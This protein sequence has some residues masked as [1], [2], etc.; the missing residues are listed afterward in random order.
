MKPAPF[1]SHA[2]SGDVARVEP[3]KKWFGKG[4]NVLLCVWWI[5]CC[6]S[7]G[8]THVI[9]QSAL[10]RFQDEMTKVMKD[11]YKV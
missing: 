11:P 1:Q 5:Y 6:T 2:Q 4:L 3:N 10:Q 9:S 8:N 7:T